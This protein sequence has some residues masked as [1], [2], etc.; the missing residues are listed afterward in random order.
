VHF[1]EFRHL[2]TSLS[3]HLPAVLCSFARTLL[4]LML[5]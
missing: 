5:R 1:R 2:P 3:A 4:V